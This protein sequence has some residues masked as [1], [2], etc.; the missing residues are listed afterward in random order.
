MTH[1]SP[2]AI[3][4]ILSLLKAGKI[5]LVCEECAES[6]AEG[7]GH[8]TTDTLRVA[9]DHRWLCEGCFDDVPDGS[10]WDAPRLLQAAQGGDDADQ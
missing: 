4:E 3:D 7:C 9:P 5:M 8:F 1:L 10:W 2:R 6:Y